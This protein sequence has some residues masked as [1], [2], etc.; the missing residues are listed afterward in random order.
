MFQ[1]N[2][3]LGTGWIIR[4]KKTQRLH[5]ENMIPVFG[6]IFYSFSSM[7]CLWVCYFIS[8]LG[9]KTKN[10]FHRIDCISNRTCY[11]KSHCT[12]SLADYVELTENA[13][14]MK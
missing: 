4:D 12:Y 14:E 7:Q 8:V 3:I 1:S 10:L 6:K 13:K 9:K 2:T 11:S 5:L